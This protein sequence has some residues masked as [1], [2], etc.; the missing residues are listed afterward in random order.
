VLSFAISIVIAICIGLTGL[1]STHR[2]TA[3]TTHLIERDV[4][5]LASVK[6]LKIEALQHRRYE[7]DFFLN[8]GKPE[9]QQK[10]IKRFNKVSGKLTRHLDNLVKTGPEQIRTT[11]SGA[12]TA[13][14][15]YHDSFLDLSRKVLAEPD[16]TPQQANRLMAPFKEQIYTFE[17]AIDEMANFSDKQ[18]GMVAAQASETAFRLEIVVAGCLAVGILLTCLMGFFLIRNLS[19]TLNRMLRGLSTISDRLFAAS[20]QV[21]DS[22]QS[23]AKGASGQAAAIEETS[24]S[25]EE[26]ATMTGKN[27]ENAGEADRL[28]REANQVVGTANSAM[29][30]LTDSMTEISRASDETSLIIKTIDEIAFQTNLLA[31]NAAVEAARAGEAGAGF[32]VVA[33]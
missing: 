20:G 2:N 21:A 14:Q 23:M 22:S 11:A 18:L 29:D 5:F 1:Y 12:L 26:M 31:L 32:A 9:K 15:D 6:L 16:I 10:Y 8:I 24:A 30:R 27:A 7:K 17:K 25:M 28:M 33:D 13:Y 4:A 19:A 3:M